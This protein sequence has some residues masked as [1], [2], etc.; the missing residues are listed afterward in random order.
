M[1]KKEMFLL[2]EKLKEYKQDSWFYAGT[3]FILAMLSG[4]FINMGH[5]FALVCVSGMVG[6]LCGCGFYSWRHK[7]LLKELEE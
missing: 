1:K 4:V 7:E 6:C 5:W 2:Q 3:S